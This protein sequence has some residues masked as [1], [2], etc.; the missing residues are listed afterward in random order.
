M[1]GMEGME[2]MMVGMIGVQRMMMRLL[3]LLMRKA[4]LQGE[5]D[6]SCRGRWSRVSSTREVMGIQLTR[7]DG[8]L[9]R[10]YSVEEIDFLLSAEIHGMA[11]AMLRTT[12]PSIR[13]AATVLMVIY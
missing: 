7:G 10:S 4:S 13:T 2:G 5:W 11:G 6:P 1:T 3:L 8:T 12:A 9:E